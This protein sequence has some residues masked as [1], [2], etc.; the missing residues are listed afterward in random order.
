MISAFVQLMSGVRI[1]H[2][3][4]WDAPDLRMMAA[5]KPLFNAFLGRRAAEALADRIAAAM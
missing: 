5:A 2:G 4:P 1:R 3:A